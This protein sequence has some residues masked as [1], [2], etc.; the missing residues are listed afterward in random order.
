M[1]TVQ[2][3]ILDQINE[4]MRLGT[5]TEGAF[6]KQITLKATSAMALRT[7]KEEFQEPSDFHEQC[8][9]CTEKI[10]FESF[11]HATCSG[12]HHVGKSTSKQLLYCSLRITLTLIDVG[13]CALTFIAITAP[14]I[15]KLCERCD[16]TFLTE[17]YG[18]YAEELAAATGEEP[19]R[20]PS[21]ADRLFK[22]FDTCPYC[23]GKFV[24]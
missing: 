24:G 4:D 9:F 14:N 16:R 10:P 1:S 22:H 17:R 11:V 6:S 5:S 2:A 20:S 12:G 8:P 7:L 19:A 15:S 13:R 3:S 21:L 18:P 23:G